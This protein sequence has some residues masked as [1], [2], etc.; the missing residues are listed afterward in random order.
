MKLWLR[1]TLSRIAIIHRGQMQL[2]RSAD[3]EKKN[4]QQLLTWPTTVHSSNVQRVRLL[5]LLLSE[6]TALAAAGNSSPFALN[7]DNFPTNIATLVNLS[8]YMNN[9]A[10]AEQSY[11]NHSNCST[12]YS[13]ILANCS[14]EQYDEYVFDRTDVR[15]LF[16]ILYSLVFCCCFFGKCPT[17]MSIV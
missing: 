10:A 1:I 2:V 16:I 5:S 3:E 17:T 12:D 8:D 6:R 7:T 14:N 15:V 4:A 13:D 9:R 11:T